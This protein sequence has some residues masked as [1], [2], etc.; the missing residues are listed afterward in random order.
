MA[1]T[2]TKKATK[3]LSR[4]KDKKPTNKKEAQEDLK[5]IDNP[6]KITKNSF[7]VLRNN[8][9][10]FL[11]IL[12]LY[13]FLSIFFV[14]GFSL[15]GDL[16]NVNIKYAHSDAFTRGINLVGSVISSSQGTTS[17]ASVYQTFFGVVVSLAVI[18][19]LREIY[20]NRKVTARNAFYKGM[21]SIIPSILILCLIGIELIPFLISAVLYAYF[22]GSQININLFEKI[23]VLVPCTLLI[24]LTCYWVTNSIIAFYISTLPEMEPLMALREAKKI[25]KKRRLKIF[26]RI[27]IFPIILFL[28]IFILMIPISLYLTAI[29]AWIYFILGLGSLIF[30]NSYMYSLYREL[31]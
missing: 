31:I 27:I 1:K 16:Q 13:F 10:L 19:C 4:N 5:K 23:I 8:W 2:K 28:T 14:H 6:F 11:S 24:W 26:A 12:A 18:Y 3:T 29:A 30:F 17:S 7:M 9:T 25:V 15:G 22:F 21:G 20:A